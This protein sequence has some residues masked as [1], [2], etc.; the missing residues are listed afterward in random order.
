MAIRTLTYLIVLGLLS[1]C[2]V[3]TAVDTVPDAENLHFTLDG[4]LF[5]SGG[6]ALFELQQQRETLSAN[7]LNG[8]DCAYTGITQIEHMLFTLC[9]EVKLVNA[10]KWLLGFN[11][12]EPD[13]QL[14]VIADL[15]HIALPN[16]LTSDGQRYLYI[17]NTAYFSQG[18]IVRIT[19]GED[20]LQNIQDI[21]TQW[22]GKSQNVSNPNG[23]QFLD[24]QL[25][26][27]DGG[28][29]KQ[30]A[31]N[32][33]GSPEP[34]RPFF[35]RNTIFDDLI[36]YCGG[37]IVTD[38]LSG[39]LFYI[40]ASGNKQYATGFASF[41]GASSVL[42][43]QPPMFD[44]NQLVITEK[45]I[46]LDELSDIGNRLSTASFDFDLNSCQ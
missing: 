37:A 29:I 30:I 34:A 3:K 43:G 8:P 22:A 44:S 24:N 18:S 23:I 1:A 15:S 19:V 5:I 46:L 28:N 35:H 41:Q 14:E 42:I 31:I 20:S 26:L 7:N 39:Q 32:D 11:L 16:G 45:G 4:R 33:D 38:Y 6:S 36:P 25:W 21:D 9:T 12:S 17:A 2:Y 27:T 10:K 13:A 40:D